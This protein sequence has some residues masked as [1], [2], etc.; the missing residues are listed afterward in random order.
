M[1]SKIM[2]D[3]L[4]R[5]PQ[6]VKDKVARQLSEPFSPFGQILP[7]EWWDWDETKWPE[8]EYI[9]CAANEAWN[10]DKSS[11][12]GYIAMK[13]MMCALVDP[14]KECKTF[15]EFTQKLKE[16]YEHRKSG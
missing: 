13:R 2:E 14:K 9:G 4:A 15:G 5:T 8:D 10:V 12:R 11:D 3:I 6:H 16:L 7:E 1:R